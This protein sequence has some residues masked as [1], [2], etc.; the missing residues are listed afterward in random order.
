MTRT[1][2]IVHL[3][4]SCD[5]KCCGRKISS[6]RFRSESERRRNI[7]SLRLRAHLVNIVRCR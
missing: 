5:H 7:P 2:R 6:I 3:Y 4:K 1:R